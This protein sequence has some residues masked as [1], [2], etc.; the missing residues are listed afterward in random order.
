M[1][2]VLLNFPPF[3]HRAKC[4]VW[5]FIRGSGV[6]A[7]LANYVLESR[8][9]APWADVQ[10]NNTRNAKRTMPAGQKRSGT[11][12]F[13]FL[14]VLFKPTEPVFSCCLL[15]K[16]AAQIACKFSYNFWIWCP[17][18][19]WSVAPFP[20]SIWTLSWSALPRL[21]LSIPLSWSKCY[22]MLMILHNS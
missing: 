2:G 3:S 22:D 20:S 4:L 17:F 5:I 6:K 14:W 13:Y 21:Y 16:S 15:P 11:I 1:L 9:T 18:S 10:P 7:L 8:P 12:V 19:K